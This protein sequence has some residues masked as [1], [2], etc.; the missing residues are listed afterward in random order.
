MLNFKRTLQ[1]AGLLKEEEYSLKIELPASI[2]AIYNAFVNNGK[3]LYLVGGAVRDALLG[4]KPKDFDLATD[5]VPTEVQAILTKSGIRNFPKGESFGVI[6]A[7]LDGHEFEIATFRGEDYTGGD[8]RR[9]TS[10]FFS[11]MATDVSRRDLT[12]NALYYDIQA[13]KVID[14][15]GGV[16]DIKNKRVKAVGDPMARFEED[17]LR[18]LRALRFAHRFGTSL[19]Q[20]T[21]DAIVHFK[22]LPGVS[23]E[24]IRDEFIK[25]LHSSLKPEE[26]LKQFASLGI[27][28]RVFPNLVLDFNFIPGLRNFC[29]VIAKLLGQNP[30]NK[31]VKV[32]R[33]ATMSVA[34]M[35]SVQFLIKLKE[36]FEDFNKLVFDPVVDGKWLFNLVKERDLILHRGE[37]TT[38][39]IMQWAVINK[40]D[41]HLMKT[42][43]DFQADITAKDFPQVTPGPEL[44]LAITKANAENFLKKF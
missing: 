16:E 30:L 4:K 5:A 24:R 9:P 7:L 18:T 38:D 25:S 39:D 14:L 44:G 17:K 3:K 22:H 26:F 21:I 20:Q 23:A 32:M 2:Q 31:I 28:P 43:L 8:G 27:M 36:R 10:V 37:V 19:D 12:I 42:F 33:E 29:L 11:D 40:I 13:G 35:D 34:E 1:I 6:S 41:A 15:V